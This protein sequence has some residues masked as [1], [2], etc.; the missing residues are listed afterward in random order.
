MENK[1]LG[2]GKYFLPLFAVIA[3]TAFVVVALRS[4]F[5]PFNHDEVATFFFYIQTGKYMPFHSHVDANNHVLNSMLGN[6]SFHLF[7]SHPFSLR[8]PNL[9]GM[10]ILILATFRL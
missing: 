5:V 1:T 10:L 2:S 6:I 3:L 9:I 7:G 4:Y 8:I